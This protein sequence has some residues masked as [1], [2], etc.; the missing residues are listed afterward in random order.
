MF[1]PSTFAL[2]SAENH[3]SELGFYYIECAKRARR[4]PFGL[5]EAKA[6]RFEKWAHTAFATSAW[7]AK[8]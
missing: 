6:Q 2:T 1:K 3:Y 7:Y 4:L 5:G 8:H